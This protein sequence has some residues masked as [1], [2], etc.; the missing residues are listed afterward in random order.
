L[1][2]DAC[3]TPT[4][5]FEV[6]SQL[7]DADR[8]LVMVADSRASLPLAYIH[9]DLWGRWC[10]F[11]MAQRDVWWHAATAPEWDGHLAASRNSLAAEAEAAAQVAAAEAASAGGVQLG[12]ADLARAGAALFASVQAP[13]TAAAE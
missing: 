11:L 12:A 5:N 8:H 3:W 7:L 13:S 6:V 4:P 1:L 10:N 9:E 2:A